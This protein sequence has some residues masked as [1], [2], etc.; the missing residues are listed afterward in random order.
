ML[1]KVI[2][3]GQTG[4]DQ[5]ALRAAKAAGIPTGGWA[6][7]GWMTEKGPALWLADFGLVECPEIGYPPRTRLN[8]RDSDATLFFGDS[9]SA[10]GIATLDACRAQHKPFMIVY[11]GVTKP[12]QVV[13]W[14]GEKGVRT[15]NVAENRESNSPGIGARVERFLA[16]VFKQL[17]AE[18]MVD[19]GER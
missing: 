11:Q 16:R 3:R 14:I 17:A 18:G 13:A 19:R 8:V 4:A 7:K 6:P 15:L 10:G 5:T 2:S 9:N 12:S 1:T